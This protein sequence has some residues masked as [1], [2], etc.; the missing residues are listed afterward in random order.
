MAMFQFQPG[1]PAK[2]TDRIHTRGWPVAPE[3]DALNSP[4]AMS[5]LRETDRFWDGDPTP[6]QVRAMAGIS[7][8]RMTTARGM[9]LVE[10]SDQP[11]RCSPESSALTRA[12]YELR[13]SGMSFADI[14][15]RKGIGVGRVH[16]RYYYARRHQPETR[17]SEL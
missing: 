5:A 16:S 10:V 1:R 17:N 8:S 4:S 9:P 13:E 2:H 12:I 7:A 14:A 6:R 11:P 15:V 3:H